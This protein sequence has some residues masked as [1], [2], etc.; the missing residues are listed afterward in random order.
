M[1]TEE[2][3]TA[4]YRKFDIEAWMPGRGEYGEVWLDASISNNSVYNY[5]AHVHVMQTF[6]KS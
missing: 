3:G 2:L 4:A 6:T 1:P 5:C